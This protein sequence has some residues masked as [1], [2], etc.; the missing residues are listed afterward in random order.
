MAITIPQDRPLIA[1]NF[2]GGTGY[3][4]G[5]EFS[6]IV[7][8][9]AMLASLVSLSFIDTST[10]NNSEVNTDENTMVLGTGKGSGKTRLMNHEAIREQIPRTMLKFKPGVFNVNVAGASGGSG[11]TIANEITRFH[12]ENGGNCINVIVGSRSSGKEIKNTDACF[13]TFASLAKKYNTPALVHFRENKPDITRSAINRNIMNNL[14]LLC[15][16]LSGKDDKM[17]E[18]DIHHLLNYTKVT[19][20]NANVVGFDLFL[21]DVSLEAHEQLYTV[22]SLALPDVNTDVNPKPE[23]Q[24]AGYLK[25]DLKDL[26][27][28]TKCM[29]WCVIGNSFGP[30]MRQLDE[31]V[32]D[33]DRQAAAHRADDFA[34]VDTD[35]IG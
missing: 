11:G 5:R 28:D 13:R 25:D 26:F 14:L 17:D 24:V 3:N 15:V 1:I 7:A 4:L 2:C 21:N 16:L 18:T 34:D 27:K 20:F 32:K 29:H 35:F 9:N 12:M 19:P 31:A 33:M 6:A 22:A 23:Y 8:E 30:M 10:A